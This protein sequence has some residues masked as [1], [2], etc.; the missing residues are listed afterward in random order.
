MEI[1]G[2]SIQ[3][4]AVTWILK[5]RGQ[6]YVESV[7]RTE[8]A[9]GAESSICFPLPSSMKEHPPRAVESVRGKGKGGQPKPYSIGSYPTQALPQRE[10]EWQMGAPRRP[11]L[12]ELRW[13]G[14]H[15]HGSPQKH[16]RNNPASA[17]CRY[18]SSHSR[19]PAFPCRPLGG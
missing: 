6:S 4:L 15:R 17:S 3:P 1:T 8:E 7:E 19:A 16:L 2:T 10:R 11:S 18:S 9:R 5:D 13:K 14:L 12:K